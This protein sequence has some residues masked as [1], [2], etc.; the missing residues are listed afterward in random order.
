LPGK[1]FLRGINDVLLE[2]IEFTIKFNKN[3][4]E[5]KVSVNYTTIKWLKFPQTLVV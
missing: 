1:W 3:P 2:N 5:R 4:D